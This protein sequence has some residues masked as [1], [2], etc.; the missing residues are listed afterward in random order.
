MFNGGT[1]LSTRGNVMGT[2]TYSEE[3]WFRA[4]NTSLNGKLMGFADNSTPTTGNQ[5]H[6]DRHIYIDPTGR[7]LFGGVAGCDG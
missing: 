4:T 5:K 7:V 3:V 6:Y 1:C 2:E